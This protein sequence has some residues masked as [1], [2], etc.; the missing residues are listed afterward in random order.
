VPDTITI[1]E[2]V[3]HTFPGFRAW[4]EGAITIT[5]AEE[6]Y[7]L[8]Q[9]RATS[10]TPPIEKRP[11]LSLNLRATVTLTFAYSTNSGAN[12]SSDALFK[13]NQGAGPSV[14][15]IDTLGTYYVKCP[16]LDEVDYVCD[17]ARD[18]SDPNNFADWPETN[19]SLS[20]YQSRVSSGTLMT[21]ESKVSQYMGRIYQKRKV[22]V[23]YK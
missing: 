9:N 13:V 11:P 7:H 23:P 19:P 14:V 15:T 20:T 18:Y 12:I 6:Y 22:A 4:N 2:E 21:I 10:P 3:S 8:V 17:D 5:A 1:G 16:A